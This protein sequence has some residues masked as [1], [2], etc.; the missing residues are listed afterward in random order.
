MFLAAGLVLLAAAGVAFWAHRTGE[1]K[2]EEVIGKSGVRSKFKLTRR[3]GINL[4]VADQAVSAEASPDTTVEA[5]I[6]WGKDLP[7]A[8]KQLAERYDA[9]TNKLRT[10]PNVQAFDETITLKVDRDL[11]YRNLVQA[12]VQGQRHGFSRFQVACLKAG[13][14]DDVGY[15]NIELP[16]M[17]P[18]G[19]NVLLFRLVADGPDI[20]YVFG[21]SSIREF[22]NLKRATDAMKAVKDKGPARLLTIQPSV[23]I[24]VQNVVEALNAATYAGFQRITLA[25]P[26]KLY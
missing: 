19:K 1:R 17:P 12:V 26:P 10:D 3:A 15:L 20:R 22:P 6:E 18:P 25:E 21:T 16:A 5:P 9:I 11:E 4:P 2:K 13:T 7:L 14:A 8:E 23:E 24:S